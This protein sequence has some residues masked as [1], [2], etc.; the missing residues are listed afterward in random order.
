[1]RR[2]ALALALA[3]CAATQLAS[4]A[5]VADEASNRQAFKHF[6]RGVTLYGE[7]DYRAA[8]VEFKRAYAVAP[9]PAVLYNV[10][11]AQYQLQDYAA[12]L[13]TFE[14]FLA[15][16]SSGDA[17]RTEV[18]SNVEILRARVG[19]MSIT[20]IPPGAEVAIDDAPVGK[21]PL[22]R[23]VLVSIGHRK[24]VAALAGRPSITRYI[25]VAADD[26]LTVTL[27][28]PEAPEQVPAPSPRL[29]TSSR[30]TEVTQSPHGGS[31]LRWL[32]WT[33]TGALAA[34]A[35]TSGIFGLRESQSLET[36]RAT[37]PTSSQTL[38][39]DAQLTTTYSIVADSLAAAAIV[40]GG[41][42]LLS[43]WL[44]PSSSPPTRGSTGTTRVVLGP[45]SARLE[46][47]F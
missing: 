38:N 5:A 33:A 19:H 13:T 46:M 26:T 17:H 45:A 15:E 11:E 20:T 30:P 14:H 32:G 16:A 27:Q 44:S 9:N 39:R 31:T 25:D 37:F 36:A 34:G 42:T 24:V 18:E 10:G 1:M 23:A 40:V 41:V 43:T 3:L 21:T 2:L 6:Q 35:I 4:S 12:A 22:E 28:L 8:L 47:T 7:A 29:E